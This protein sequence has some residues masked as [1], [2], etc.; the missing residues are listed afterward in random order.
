MQIQEDNVPGRG[1]RDRR[2]QGR[3]WCK[4]KARK[5]VKVRLKVKIKGKWESVAGEKVEKKGK[6]SDPT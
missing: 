6:A 1:K 3:N 4:V 5:N 2:L